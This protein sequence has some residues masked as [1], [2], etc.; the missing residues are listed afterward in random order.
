MKKY[1]IENQKKYQSAGPRSGGNA[2]RGASGGS[3]RR[4]KPRYAVNLKV[5]MITKGLNHHSIER[6]ANVSLGGIFV[7]TDHLA[8][9]GEKVHI[10][11][12]FSDKDSYFDVKTQVAW[13]SNSEGPH[14]QGLGLE[15]I[16]LSDAHKQ[17]IAHFLKD[18]VNVQSD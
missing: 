11:I 18:Y 1:C 14:P 5:E 15:F 10:R 2:P 12:I 6:C 7:C 9:L 8:S 4:L 16:E 3:N 17:V 13:I